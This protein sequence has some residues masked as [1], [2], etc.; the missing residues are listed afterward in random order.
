MSQ[1]EPRVLIP[2]GQDLG[3]MST[4]SAD[5]AESRYAYRVFDGADLHDLDEDEYSVWSAAANDAR[6]DD[7]AWGSELAAALPDIDDLRAVTD[8]LVERGLL[9]EVLIGSDD[10][11]RFSALHRVDAR[12]P[13][14]G[15]SVDQPGDVAIGLPGWPLVAVSQDCA[16][17]F[18]YGP[19]FDD[20]WTVCGAVAEVTP[21]P[22]FE[23]VPKQVM[24]A[25][26]FLMEAPGLLAAGALC[27][28]RA[29]LDR[30]GEIR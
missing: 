16:N 15:P 6:P 12:M 19:V 29:H 18:L 5:S 23:R 30:S 26:L 13:V 8:S 4:D 25:E 21:T 7:A 10:A 14:L 22:Q 9:V 20:L 28:M 24:L 27:F 17:V 3:P 1:P 2:V 11:I